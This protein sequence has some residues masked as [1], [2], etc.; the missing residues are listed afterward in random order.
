MERGIVK[1]TTVDRLR[2]VKTYAYP[3][4]GSYA[5]NTAALANKMALGQLYYAREANADF[6]CITTPTLGIFTRQIYLSQ[7]GYDP[8]N[9][10]MMTLTENLDAVESIDL[11][12]P[13]VDEFNNVYAISALAIQPSTGILFGATSGSSP[14]S[15]GYLVTINTTTGQV[16]PVGPLGGN[17][18]TNPIID[19][20]FLID[21]SLYGWRGNRSLQRIN[22]DTG[23]ATQIGPSYPGWGGGGFATD[24]VGNIY[25]TVNGSQGNLQT[26]DRL[27][28]ITTVLGQ[29]DG[30]P[31]GYALTSLTICPN[32]G[33][34]PMFAIYNVNQA[35][36]RRLVRIDYT[37]L[38]TIPVT[39]VPGVALPDWASG[40]AWKIPSSNPKVVQ[41]YNDLQNVSEGG[42]YGQFTAML[43]SPAPQNMSIP[44]TVTGTASPSDYVLSDVQF[45]FLAGQTTSTITV[46]ATV[47]NVPEPAETVIINMG[48]PTNPTFTVYP[49]PYNQAQMSIINVDR[50]ISVFTTKSAA[51]V[52]NSVQ[53]VMRLDLTVQSDQTLYVTYSLSGTATQGVDYTITPAVVEFP[54][55]TSS[56]YI[57]ITPLDD[58]VPLT[59]KSVIVTLTGVTGDPK[60]ILSPVPSN[61]TATAS[62]VD[63][64]QGSIYLDRNTAK[65]IQAIGPVF[66]AIAGDLT[67]EFY[68]NFQNTGAGTWQWLWDA[69]GGIWGSELYS[70]MWSMGASPFWSMYYP[71]GT[72]TFASSPAVNVW[73][74]YALT[75]QGGTWRFFIN[76]NNANTF[77]LS[78]P[79]VPTNQ[80]T[81]GNSNNGFYPPDPTRGLL[82]W[83]TNFRVTIGALYTA[84]FTPSSTPLTALPGT[85]LFIKG[86]VPT[87]PEADSSAITTNTMFNSGAIWSA[88]SPFP[89]P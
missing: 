12:G 55:Y 44:F 81:M 17:A 46:T 14:T 57:F 85:I 56:Q 65:Y 32:T 38:P 66:S 72:I 78:F 77:G 53:A 49:A 40:M 83:I 68:A 19:M 31:N 82:G 18:G 47:D 25:L 24:P 33:N 41:I 15:Y 29:I 37:T 48:V 87:I 75:R 4:P 59:D 76:G 42:M 67:I 54:P 26:I 50:W 22:Y 88:L 11:I 8:G 52:D 62:V 39:D 79:P 86:N 60:F 28:G 71:N 5:T 43:S 2:A 63:A 36:E 30:D 16:T 80:I 9:L 74:H 84:N 27:T 51:I 7:S 64:V 3:I 73:R 34:N 23:A 58:S 89:F 10:Y 21:G 1:D 13:F 35:N 61:I 20:E 70:L 69:R 6:V 45:T